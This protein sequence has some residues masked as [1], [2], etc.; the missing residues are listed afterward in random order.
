MRRKWMAGAVGSVLGGLFVMASACGPAAEPTASAAAPTATTAA[1]PTATTAAAPTATTASTAPTATR[2]AATTVAATA[3]AAEVKL[4]PVPVLAVPAPNPSA[5][6]GGIFRSLSGTDMANFGIYDSGNGG[7]MGASVPTTDSLLDRNEFEANKED[8]ILPALAYD[9]WTDKSGLVWTFKL[10]DNVK[11]SDGKPFTCA[12]AEFSLEVIR[13][14]HDSKGSTL[15]NTARGVWLG[16][17]KDISCPDAFTLQI[18][19][20]GPLMSL[21]ATLAVSSFAIIPKHIHEGHLDLWLKEPLKVGMG[22]FLFEQ[23]IPTEVYKL[24]RNPNYWQQPYP[25][26]D[27][28]HMMNVGS[29]TAA[30]GAF[31]VGRGESGG[32][33]PSNIRQEMEAAGKIYVQ[34][35]VAGDGLSA[36]QTNWSK[37]PYNDKRFAQALRCAINDAKVIKL[38]FDGDGFE[39]PIV[40]LPG[41]PGGATWGITKEEWKAIGPCYGPTEETDMAK[42]QQIAKDLL[43]AMGFTAQNPA[44]PVVVWQSAST[45][46]NIWASLEDDLKQVGIQPVMQYS[47]SEQAYAKSVAGEFDIINPVQQGFVTSRRDPDHWLYEQFYSTSGRNYGRYIN[48]EADALIDKQSRTLDPAE[49]LRLIKQVSVMLLKDNAKVIYKHALRRTVFASWVKDA[50]PGEPSNSQNTYTKRQRVWID[51]AKMKQVLGQ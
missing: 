9:W 26:L 13:D 37:P 5:Q 20:D 34:G 44:K 7:T 49:R 16:R 29:E 33:L 42:R 17:A 19:T 43:A 28:V 36:L 25:Y 10:H 31:R 24:K 27:S 21:P 32:T 2:P 41:T 51:Q 6:K 18:K 23:Y 47:T 22:P 40:P 14:G 46:K 38:A 8:Q 50:Y 3:T 35:N 45:S 4:R 15:T 12:D 1:A 39:G 48:P 11:F 30:T